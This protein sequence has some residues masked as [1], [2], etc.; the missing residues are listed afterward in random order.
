MGMLS[1][2]AGQV[3]VQGPL[4][5]DS[6]FFLSGFLGTYV[7]VRKLKADYA[8]DVLPKFPW[9]Y[10]LRWLRLVIPMIFVSLWMLGISP[11]F[12]EIGPSEDLS[13]CRGEKNV[14]QFIIHSS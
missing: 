2:F 5:V 10:I 11:L 6:F 1:T 8:M 9:V 13:R 4:S 12:T 3:F 7:A 14:I